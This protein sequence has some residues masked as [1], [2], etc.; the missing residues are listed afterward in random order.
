VPYSFSAIRER[1]VREKKKKRKN[2][3]NRAEKTAPKITPKLTANSGLS[4]VTYRDFRE[5]NL[6][7]FLV[8]K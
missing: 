4:L 1:R 6:K 2:E 5:Y 8:I 7:I 3:R